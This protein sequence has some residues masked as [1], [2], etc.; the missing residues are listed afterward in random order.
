LLCKSHPLPG[1]VCL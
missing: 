1:L